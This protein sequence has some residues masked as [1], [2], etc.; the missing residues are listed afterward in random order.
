MTFEIL[1]MIVVLL[2]MKGKILLSLLIMASVMCLHFSMQKEDTLE[3]TNKYY[4]CIL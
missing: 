4:L 1:E 3:H 2:N